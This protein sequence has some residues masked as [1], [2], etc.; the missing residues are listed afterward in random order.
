MQRA[1][2]RGADARHVARGRQ[3]SAQ[4]GGIHATCKK[5]RNRRRG[6]GTR[7]WG[8]DTHKVRDATQGDGC[9]KK[10][11]RARESGVRLAVGARE[12][13]GARAGLP[14]CRRGSSGD[15]TRARA[16][17]LVIK[18]IISTVRWEGGR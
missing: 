10:R 11:R 8:A 15:V 12:R 4:A 3:S 17:E 1:E 14:G 13:Q 6:R 7:G 9:S 5:C 16:R 2:S 18:I